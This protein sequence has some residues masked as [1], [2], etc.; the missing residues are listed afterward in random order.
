MVGPVSIAILTHFEGL[1][2][3]RVDRGKLHKLIDV[4]GIA[5]CAFLCGAE[6]W[7]DVERYGRIKRKWLAK[8][9]ELPN[10]IPSHD[11]F[12]RVFNAL[13]PAEFVA[14]LQS[15]VATLQEEMQGRHIAIDGKTVCG[16]F[17]KA[18]NRA[19]LHLVSAWSSE[20]GI[21]LGQVA[22]DQKSNEITAVPSLLALLE[23][24]GATVT[25][26]AMHCQK[27]TAAAIRGRDADYVLAVKA[28]QEKLHEAVHEAFL[29]YA[30]KDF[31]SRRLR[32]HTTQEHC[33][34][35][36]ERREYFVAP[37]P[38]ALADS[39]EWRDL[40]SIGMVI[41]TRQLDGQEP[42]EEVSYYISSLPPKVKRFARVV[43]GHW[44]IENSLHWSLDVTFAEDR[45]RI[46][47]GK[48]P[49][50]VALLRRLTLSI[51]KQDTSLDESLRGKR[52]MAGWN[53]RTLERILCGFRGD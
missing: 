1:T 3:P 24:E 49:E 13:K 25:L 32:R 19:A 6:G 40:A 10:G 20:V 22:V 31:S 46:R 48:G 4:L 37:A 33:H 12:R 2:D 17:D 29:L 34:G 14:C 44:S 27:E 36:Q 11:T 35:R 9:L 30:E 18:T 38:Q 5:L 26:D 28:N 8:W 53:N 16:S 23:L 50:N 15:F 41:R 7:E 21:S 39:G 51:L 52:L 47:R 45:C 43:R 42:S